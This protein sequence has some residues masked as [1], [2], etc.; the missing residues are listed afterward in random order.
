MLSAEMNTF[1]TRTGAGAPMGEL[2]RRFWFPA[3]FSVD[4]PEPDCAP[5]RMRLLGEDLVAYRDSTGQVGLVANACPHRGA[6]LFFGR[7]EES[8]LRCVYHGWKFDLEGNCVDMP[9]EPAESNF[10]HKIH[11]AAY[12][13]AERSGVVWAYMGPRDKMGAVPELE[14]TRVPQSHLFLSKRLQECNF[15]QAID[16][17]I[18]SSHVS[19]LHSNVASHRDTTEA[20][21]DLMAV[22]KH[23]HFE[24]ADTDYGILIGARRHAPND[25][26]YWRMHQFLVP[27]FQMIPAVLGGPVS[28]HVW[29]PIDDHRCWAW[30]MTWDPEKPLTQDTAGRLAS[31][32]G[33]HA[34]V[35]ANYRPLANRDN[36]YLVD[37]AAQ[38]TVSFSGIRGIG[39]QDMATQESM[40]PVNDR[41]REH[42]GSSD[43]AVIAM[44]RRLQRLAMDL[45]RG[46]EPAAAQ[47]PEIYKVRSVSFILNQDQSWVEECYRTMAATSAFYP[48]SA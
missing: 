39:E 27:F 7:N 3:F 36:D 2:I 44:R 16:G 41:T 47:Q 12:P 20:K 31:G 37:R 5:I 35:D 42:L 15:L 23:P 32:S 26:Y 38:R 1:M 18:D 9:N 22:D 8:G 33:I 30:S 48:A 45:Q 21:T 13:T 40:G 19:F 28:G 4:L 29:V 11:V 25:S 46:V 14:W 6:S 34:T 17:G 43:T 24:L 10:K